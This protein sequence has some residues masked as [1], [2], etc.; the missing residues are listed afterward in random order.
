[1]KGADADQDLRRALAFAGDDLFEGFCPELTELKL[2]AGDTLFNVGDRATMVYFL[3]TGR[4]AVRK[5]T[6]F[7][8][9]MQVVALLDPGAPVGEGAVFPGQ[10]HD[11]TVVAVEESRLVALP[12]E[13]LQGLAE[14]KPGLAWKII[15]RLLLVAHLRLKKNSDRLARVL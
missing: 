14:E 6:G 12:G 9:K 4:L 2:A 13:R 1:M 8:E 15:T 10:V 3:V 5:S 7:A 11:S